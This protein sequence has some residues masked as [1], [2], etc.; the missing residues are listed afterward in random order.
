MV[1]FAVD[2]SADG[3][4]HVEEREVSDEEIATLA[5]A[6]AATNPAIRAT[7]RAESA[8][9]HGRVMAIVDLL[10]TAG[11]NKVAFA[12]TPKAAAP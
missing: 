1:F 5:S 10:K 6:A 2:V 9:T 11:I 7:I 4:A 8:V 12:A 3:K